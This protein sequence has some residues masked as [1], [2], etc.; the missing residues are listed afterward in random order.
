MS[1]KINYNKTNQWVKKFL[2]K[3]KAKTKG[4]LAKTMD[5]T[6]NEATLDLELEAQDYLP[7]V[8]EG[9]NGTK[10]NNN[11]PYSYKSKKPPIKEISVWAKSKG[12]NPWALQKSLYK[13][14]IRGQNI[15][16]QPLTKEFSE[17]GDAVAEDIA[18]SIEENIKK[19]IK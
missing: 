8:D 17:F 7:Y 3:T 6:F 2:S 10:R 4:N 14:G 18:D 13:N 9:V 16:E 5:M 19:T 1:V 15:L 12:I 11:S